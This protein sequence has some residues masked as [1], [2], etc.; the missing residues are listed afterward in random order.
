MIL[1]DLRIRNFRC[2]EELHLRFDDRLTVLV[3]NNGNG[4]TS[5]LDAIAIAFGPFLTRIPGVKGKDFKKDD[6]RIDDTGKQAPFRAI[7]ARIFIGEKKIE[8]VR[9][10]KRD[11]SK[12]TENQIRAAQEK[13]NLEKRYDLSQSRTRLVELTEFADQLIEAQHRAEPSTLPILAYYG[14]GRGVFSVPER[15]RGFQKDF[16]RFDAYDG[17]LDSKTNFRKFFEYFYFLEDLENRQIKERRDFDYRNPELEVIRTAI[18]TF[19]EEFS[20]PRTELRPLRFMLDHKKD[21]VLRAFDLRMLSDGYRTSLG[22]VMD[23]ASRMAEANPHLGADALRASGVVLIDE[24][25]MH[26]HPDW[27]QH[28][29]Q[30]LQR[31]FPKVQIICTTHSPQVLSTVPKQSIVI[32]G[33]DHQAR[34]PD[35]QTRGVPSNEILSRV[36]NVDPTP[37]VKEASLVSHYKD[38]IQSGTAQTEQGVQLWKALT[39]HYGEGHPELLECQRLARL[40]AFKKKISTGEAK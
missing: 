20:N 12:F 26:L 8:W 39:E 23:L 6:P 9:F 38:L 33:D 13:L 35:E 34:G 11:Q 37:E 40:E 25:D 16:P 15:R 36:M 29:I 24:I 28:I 31:T 19:L 27:Q 18:T 30:D 22:V 7:A 1:T 2:F 4:K 17:C 5:I 32:F 3:A 21:G 14:T 10:E